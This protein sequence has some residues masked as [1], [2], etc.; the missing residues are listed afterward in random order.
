[1]PGKYELVA[2]AEGYLPQVMEVEVAPF[3]KGQEAQRVDFA[4]QGRDGPVANDIVDLNDG[5]QV[6]HPVL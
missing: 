5:R 2:Q 1:M 3:Q 4:M 6:G